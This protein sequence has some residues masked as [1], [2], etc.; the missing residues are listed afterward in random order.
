MQCEQGKQASLRRAGQAGQADQAGQAGGA[1]MSSLL[2][3]AAKPARERMRA[4]NNAVNLFTQ[5][6]A[7]IWRT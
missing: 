7:T 2:S 1:S 6:S 3:A 4:Y 5:E